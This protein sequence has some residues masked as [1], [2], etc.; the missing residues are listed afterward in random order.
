VAV[1][2]PGLYQFQM[3]LGQCTYAAGDYLARVRIVLANA[4]GRQDQYI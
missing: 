3:G 2:K 4:I 1:I